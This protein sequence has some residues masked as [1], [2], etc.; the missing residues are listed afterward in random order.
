M[1]GTGFF[2]KDAPVGS[3]PTFSTE[4]EQTDDHADCTLLIAVSVG[5]SCSEAAP[6]KER[7]SLGSPCPQR[8]AALQRATN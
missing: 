4:V 5:G 2:C 1:Q 6:F 3:S 7:T 8:V